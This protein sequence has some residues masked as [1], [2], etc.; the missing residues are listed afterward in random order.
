MKTKIST[1]IAYVLIT[2]ITI[3]TLNAC[4]KTRGSY[5]TLYAWLDAQSIN[6]SEKIHWDII[7]TYHQ[8]SNI[9][10][11][12]IDDTLKRSYIGYYDQKDTTLRINIQIDRYRNVPI[13]SQ[14]E[15]T[16]SYDFTPD[17]VF[18]PEIKTLSNY[19]IKQNE[20]GKNSEKSFTLCIVHFNLDDR[21]AVYV[22]AH[23]NDQIS[24]DEWNK[25][26]NSIFDG[27]KIPDLANITE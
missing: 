16:T 22:V 17:A 4:Y 15:T 18:T 2:A 25:I 1:T 9:L 7:E 13:D 10:T 12:P 24:N 11:N 6:F 8:T 5:S 23:G 19:N 27:M 3:A 26:L 14:N 20:C 21:Y